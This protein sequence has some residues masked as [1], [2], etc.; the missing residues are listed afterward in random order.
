MGNKTQKTA[1]IAIVGRANVGKS[2]F[3]NKAIGQKVAI[4][5]NK[6]QTTRT[7]IMGALTKEDTQLIFIDTP[8]FHKPKNALG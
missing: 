5:S 4:V 1:F 2:S 6:P 7:R 3:L 8:G